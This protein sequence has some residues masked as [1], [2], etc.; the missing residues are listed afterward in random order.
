MINDDMVKI[1]GNIC[2]KFQKY[3]FWSLRS[4]MVLSNQHILSKSF[5]QRC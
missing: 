1:L 3:Y 4:T 2:Y 5:L